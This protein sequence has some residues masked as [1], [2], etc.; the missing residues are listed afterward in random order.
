MM[1][2]ALM[3]GLAVLVAGCGEREHGLPRFATPDPLPQP[4]PQPVPVPPASPLTLRSIAVGEEVKDTFKGSPLGFELTAP[5][6]GTLVARLTWDVWYN[7]T[8]MVLEMD[9]TRFK[10]V[11]PDWSPV[12]GRLRVTAG[13]TCK[14]VISPGGSDW[15]YDDAFVLTT[16]IE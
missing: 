13:Q 9:G 4:Q 8:L 6:G 1:R 7:G 12:V 5:A 3:L 15:F 2:L 14:L 16:S 11:G 10:P